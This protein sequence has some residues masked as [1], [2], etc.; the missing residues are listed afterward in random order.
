MRALLISLLLSGI[1]WATGPEPAARPWT[2]IEYGAA[3]Y[4]PTD[5]GETLRNLYDTLDLFIRRGGPEGVFYVNDSDM[6]RTRGAAERLAQYIS[7]RNDYRRAGM[8]ELKIEVRALPGDYTR[9]KLPT[10]D[11][12]HLK[13]PDTPF[14]RDGEKAATALRRMAQQSTGGLEI[15]TYFHSLKDGTTV[16]AYEAFHRVQEMLSNQLT[17]RGQG[18][19]YTFPG[20]QNP[21][22][23]SQAFVLAPTDA[24]PR[25][26]GPMGRIV[27]APG[28]SQ[29]GICRLFW[30]YFFGP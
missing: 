27:T 21:A 4:N 22:G 9:I 10:T 17:V 19:P 13:H 18:F 1:V 15:H 5:E 29:P 6:T 7:D 14:L 2:H 16:D 8:P 28:Q 12:A 26:T 23:G 3:N 30:N 20:R 11:T 25:P 24:S